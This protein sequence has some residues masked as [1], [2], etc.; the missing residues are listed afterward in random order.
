M[1]IVHRDRPIISHMTVEK[2][3]SDTV[4]I[5]SDGAAIMVI[6]RNSIAGIF[7]ELSFAIDFANVKLAEQTA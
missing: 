5:V 1:A 6:V 2:K 7:S 4:S 3:L